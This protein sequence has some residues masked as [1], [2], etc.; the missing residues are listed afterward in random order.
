[1]KSDLLYVS[2]IILLLF[3]MNYHVL[4]TWFMVDDTACIFSSS[5]DTVKLLFDR[6]T[7]IF[8][9]QFFFSPGLPI[10][11]KIDWF[12]F[13]M[14]P[15]GYHIH[16]FIAA[17]LCCILFFKL[18]RIYMP[19]LFSWLGTLFMSSSLPISFD[20]GWITRRHYLWG[21]FFSLMTIYLFKKWEEG[22]RPLLMML[23]LFS[24]LIAFLFKEAYLFLP[25]VIF[26]ISSGSVGERLKR[27]AGYIGIFILY[28]LWRIHMLGGLGGYTGS[29]Q[30]SLYYFLY[31]WVYIPVDISGNLVFPY[32]PI[33]IMLLLILI[34]LNNF[35]MAIGLLFIILTISAPFIFFPS[36]GFSL[37]NKA[38]SFAAVIS[39]T[40][41]YSI[42]SSWASKKKAVSI[43]LCGLF[44]FSL[45]GSFLQAKSGHD[46]ILK[47]SNLHEKASKEILSHKDEKILVISDNSYYFS[48]LADIYKEMLKKEFPEIKAASTVKIIP[49]LESYDFD[50]IIVIEG[51]C[52]D[53]SIIS[54]SKMAI[55]EGEKA[56]DF[57]AK[58]KKE[59]EGEFLQEP[60]VNFIQ[61]DSY[62]RIHIVDQRKGTYM[63]CLYR[64][65]YIGCYPIPEIYVFKFNSVKKFEKIAIIYLSDK[66]KMSNPTTFRN[67]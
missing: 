25:A 2:P 26:I 51:L 40:L 17:S 14:H 61:T 57:L 41:T 36:G 27:S 31:K 1:M 32:F 5:L 49:I 15:T 54:R 53:P 24:T 44:S 60:H 3:L 59:S 29:T 65:T 35:R 19:L 30:K 6:G 4:D 52:L 50:R 37:A 42:Y 10:S 63:R 18:Q 33:V 16:N 22:K 38:L 47:Q 48:N 7:Y 23:S 64:D 55:L 58:N 28:L 45:Y 67:F 34:A 12:L 11:F 21:F 39:F 13:N 20:I 56:R 46:V 9:N 43:F 62:L 66:G 8:F